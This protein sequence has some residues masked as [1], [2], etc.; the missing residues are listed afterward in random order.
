M[1]RAA[2]EMGVD[3]T[4]LTVLSEQIEF[5]DSRRASGAVNAFFLLRPSTALGRSRRIQGLLVSLATWQNW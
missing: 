5:F 2:N 4:V 1:S 3:T